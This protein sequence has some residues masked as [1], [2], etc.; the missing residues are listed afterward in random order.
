MNITNANIQFS[1]LS[2]LDSKIVSHRLS[3]PYEFYTFK[4][5]PTRCC[6]DR[7]KSGACLQ[8]FLDSTSY[9][10]FIYCVNIQNRSILPLKFS[11]LVRLLMIVYLRK[12]FVHF[13]RQVIPLSLLLDNVDGGAQTVSF[14]RV[15]TDT[16]ISKLNLE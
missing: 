14:R 2:L 8:I 7:I 10:I 1:I 12:S 16:N 15:N 13:Y 9:L 6:S 11:G 3:N 5:R 4:P